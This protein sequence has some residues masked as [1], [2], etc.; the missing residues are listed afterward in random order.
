MK[1]LKDL[2]F[3]SC[4]NPQDRLACYV[5]LLESHIEQQNHLLEIFKQELQ[6]IVLELSQEQS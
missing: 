2:A 6:Q 3:Q 1:L 5:T 4:N